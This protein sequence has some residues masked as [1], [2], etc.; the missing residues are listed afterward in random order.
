M[1][2]MTPLWQKYSLQEEPEKLLLPL[3]SLDYI[4]VDWK[5]DPLQEVKKNDTDQALVKWAM[6]ATI[7]MLHP[8]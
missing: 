1:L 2:K 4:K 5:T 7:Q 6:L 8:E 3:C